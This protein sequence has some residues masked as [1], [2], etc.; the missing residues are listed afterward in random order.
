MT[1]RSIFAFGVLT[2]LSFASAACVTSSNIVDRRG[3]GETRCYVAPFDALWPAVE[4]GVRELGLVL[5]RSNRENG[6]LVARTYQPEDVPPEDMAL[7]SSAGERVGVFLDRDSLDDQNRDIWAI[8]VISRP[9]FNLDVTARD[10][11]RAVFLAIEARIPDEYMGPGE[12]RAACS[13]VRGD[14]RP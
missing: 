8:E 1:R 11:T 12:D 2:A 5:E 7:E 3:T 6:I 13:R 4:D 10:W 9:I 14:T